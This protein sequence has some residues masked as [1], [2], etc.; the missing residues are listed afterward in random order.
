[1]S[2][3][4]LSVE[5]PTSNK[6]YTQNTEFKT[7]CGAKM[8]RILLIITYTVQLMAHYIGQFLN[9]STRW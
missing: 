8:S 6:I 2:M 3:E 7:Y 4:S 9:V 1:M 5:T